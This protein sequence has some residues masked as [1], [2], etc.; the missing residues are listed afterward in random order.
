M[1]RVLV[2][3][4]N[5]FSKSNSN[6]RTLGN[7]FYSY[8][9][10]KI[11]QFYISGVEDDY[12]C[13]HFYRVSDSDVINSLM[14]LNGKFKQ[15][16]KI[17][18]FEKTTKTRNCKNMI[19]RNIAWNLG[20]WKN[21]N[22]KKWLDDF[23]PECILLQ[24][25]DCAFMIK[26]ALWCAKRFKSK[27]FIY[28][29][30][31]YYFKNFNYF[32]DGHDILYKIFISN[33]KRWFRKIIKK[34]EC[35]IYLCDQLKKDYDNEFHK[36]SVVIYNSSSISLPP[37]TFDNFP[38]VS[39]IGNLE[40]DRDK[41]LCDIAD[42]LQKIDISLKIDVYGRANEETIKLFKQHNGINYCGFISYNEVQQVMSKTHILLHVEGFNEFYVEDTKYGFSGK[43]ADNL[44][45]GRVFFVY[46]PKNVALVQY[47]KRMNHTMVFTDKCSLSDNIHLIFNKQLILSTIENEKTIFDKNHNLEK[48]SKKLI[49]L[50]N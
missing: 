27:I 46:A 6:G 17:E 22:L 49:A 18:S 41:S 15:Q 32:R 50:I 40:L 14:F 25:G 1:K 43:V 44:G 8:E 34:A 42:A 35:S 13:E 19:L 2:I 24:I 5:C 33:Y 12:F 16:D 37:M 26:F 21:N 29:T 45:S 48:N 20:F 23:N 28:N 36:K 39:Y 38:V 47:L 3:S 10:D 30:E 11:A 7:L 4:N 9:K 31:G